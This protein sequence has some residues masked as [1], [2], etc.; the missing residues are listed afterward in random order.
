M[1]WGENIED[2]EE[3]K[4]RSNDLEEAK[5]Q[6]EYYENKA[7]KY[8]DAINKVIEV[9]YNKIRPALWTRIWTLAEFRENILEEVSDLL[10]D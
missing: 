1:N 6:R 9:T 10:K 3:D 7:N 2:V 5:I 4:S 8:K